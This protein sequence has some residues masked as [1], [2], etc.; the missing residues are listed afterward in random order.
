LR[1]LLLSNQSHSMPRTGVTPR[2]PDFQPA[3]QLADPGK[4]PTVKR[5][6]ERLGGSFST[7]IPQLTVWTAAQETR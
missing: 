2:A 5:V 6:R 1:Y 3:G 4:Q 7:V